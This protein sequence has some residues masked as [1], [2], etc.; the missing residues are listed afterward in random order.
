MGR[1]LPFE[2]LSL[3][4]FQLRLP[5][6][7]AYPPPPPPLYTHTLSFTLL[8]ITDEKVSPNSNVIIFNFFYYKNRYVSNSGCDE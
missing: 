6:S 7:F 3:S 4:L 8:F 2:V 1:E 5:V